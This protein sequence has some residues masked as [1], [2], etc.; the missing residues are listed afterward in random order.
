MAI[1]TYSG[2]ITALYFRAFSCFR[3]WVLNP[4]PAAFVRRF[5]GV[6]RE[7]RA[8][9]WPVSWLVR[10]RAWPGAVRS[11]AR[12]RAALARHPYGPAWPPG[13]ARR[14]SRAWQV[15]KE[16]TRA[17]PA[18][19][20]RTAARRSRGYSHAS[21]QSHQASGA[22]CVREHTYRDDYGGV[23]RCPPV[24]RRVRKEAV[25][26]CRCAA[27]MNRETG[28]RSRRGWPGRPGGRQRR[29]CRRRARS[30]VGD[31]ELAAVGPRGQPG[32][33]GDDGD[34]GPGGGI[35]AGEAVPGEQRGE[36]GGGAGGHDGRGCQPWPVPRGS[37]GSPAL[38]MSVV[39]CGGPRALP[40][41]DGGRRRLGAGRR[42]GT[43]TRCRCGGH[44]PGCRSGPGAALS[45]GRPGTAALRCGSR[46][47][48]F[49]AM[50][51]LSLGSLVVAGMLGQVAL[52]PVLVAGAE[53][54]G[55]SLSCGVIRRAAG[56]GAGG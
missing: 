2:R 36:R 34:A 40:S 54:A 33:Y 14:G 15:G 45:S 1:I 37:A 24:P 9:V 23:R 22:P 5:W 50:S 32:G 49:A 16:P 12:G 44:V 38:V 25:I 48:S 11:P 30:V 41:T 10:G 19:R 53:A 28:V 31:P 52:K 26:R 47:V 3:H 13:L 6:R 4:F 7:R 43:R 51:R 8:V 21:P 55:G 56:G 27:T 46:V 17:A 18:A 39:R 42:P 20:Q 29:W 35:G